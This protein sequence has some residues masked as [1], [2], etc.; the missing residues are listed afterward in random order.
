MSRRVVHLL[1]TQ[2]SSGLLYEVDMRLKPSGKGGLL[3]T[4]LKAFETYQRQ[5]AWTWEHQALLRARAVAGEGSVRGKFETIRRQILCSCVRQEELRSD[6]VEMRD[7]MYRERGAGEQSGFDIKKDR[8][9]ITDIEFLVQFLV[10]NSVARH[11]Q[12]VVYSDVIRQLESLVEE[13]MIDKS[14]AAILRENWLAYRLRVHH[15]ALAQRS[16][17]V[18]ESE[19][20]NERKEVG[21]LWHKYLGS[22]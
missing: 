14:E 17:R 1:S 5:T 13:D 18:D 19:F 9:G 8:G 10:L 3:V 22:D 20:C 6:I 12:L 16:E 11:P 4:S 7:R 21:L 15:L 2:T